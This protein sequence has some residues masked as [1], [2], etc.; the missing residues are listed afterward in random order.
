MIL[1]IEEYLND[2]DCPELCNMSNFTLIP[3]KDAELTPEQYSY[4]LA[5]GDTE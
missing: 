3:P 1:T 2:A 5:Y 4:F